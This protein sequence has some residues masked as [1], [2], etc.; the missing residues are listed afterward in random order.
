VEF[1]S[2]ATGI[3]LLG[4]DRVLAAAEPV[5]RERQRSCA[6]ANPRE[7]GALTTTASTTCGA[8][9][10]WIEPKASRHRPSRTG[11][12]RPLNLDATGGTTVASLYLPTGN[13]IIWAKL[14]VV[15]LVGTPFKCSLGAGANVDSVLRVGGRVV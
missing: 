9:R 2:A 5:R 13:Y 4:D 14:Q 7:S 10:S 11:N 1:I 12:S 6:T 3:E 8:P 15:S